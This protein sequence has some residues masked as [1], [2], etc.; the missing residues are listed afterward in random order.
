MSATNIEWITVAVLGFGALFAFFVL[1]FIFEQTV[2]ALRYRDQFAGGAGFRRFGSRR[3]SSFGSSG[4]T[5]QTAPRRRD[6]NLDRELARQAARIA[7]GGE[8][9]ARRARSSDT[10]DEDGFSDAAARERDADRLEDKL[11][12]SP[13]ASVAD[14]LEHEDDTA[15]PAVI[16]LPPLGRSAVG[17]PIETVAA[18]AP[19][20]VSD[21]SDEAVRQG[22]DRPSKP[23]D[24]GLGAEAQDGPKAPAPRPA[25]EPLVLTNVVT[26]EA[27]KKAPAA[28]RSQGTQGT[29]LVASKPLVSKRV[30]F[31]GREQLKALRAK[32]ETPSPK[33]E[34]AR[35][36]RSMTAFSSGSPASP[37]WPADGESEEATARPGPTAEQAARPDPGARAFATTRPVQVE[38]RNT[39]SPRAKTTIRKDTAVRASVQMGPATTPLTPRAEPLPA[40]KPAVAATPVEPATAPAPPAAVEPAVAPPRERL[41]EPVAPP[42]PVAAK[43]APE[44]QRR[45]KV[46]QPSQPENEVMADTTR[47]LKSLREAE[48]LGL[49]PKGGC[50]L[51]IRYKSSSGIV[52][53]R[54]I[55]AVSLEEA[56]GEL[57]MRAYCHRSKA[58]RRIRVSHVVAAFD[59]KTRDV[60]VGGDVTGFI[61]GLVPRRGTADPTPEKAS[62]LSPAAAE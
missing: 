29:P 12:P 34:Q 43:E 2:H 19:A 4:L 55:Q 42:Q 6:P 61:S 9:E 7:A 44:A 31:A 46:V 28:P 57:I 40:E 49:G 53:D 38:T 10:P 59:L 33:P 47:Q 27:R 50:P 1:V 22:T 16:T 3:Y 26:E 11:D 48:E 41:A 15:D 60:A 13:E 35:A 17:E 30:K 62:G 32:A 21:P 45:T 25:A 23:V 18:M 36:D 58:M 5:Q 24:E 51:Y 54:I 52:F 37:A 8:A 56:D 20:A 39:P 14:G